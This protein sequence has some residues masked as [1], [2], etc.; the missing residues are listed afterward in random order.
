MENQANASFQ[1]SHMR[2]IVHDLFQ[3]NP[4]F[5]WADFLLTV[6]VA[7]GCAGIYFLSPLF[8]AQQILCLFVAG[9]ALHRLANFIHEI[10]HLHS[11]RSLRSF[12]VAWDI[13]V[14]IPTLMPSYFFHNHMAHHNANHFGTSSDC[15]YIPLGRG[16]LRNIGFFMCEIFLQPLFVVFRHAVVGPIS[17]LHPRLRQWVLENFSS[18]VFVWPCPRKI[19]T[20]APRAA[21]AAMDIACWLRASAIFG[22]VVLEVNP[23]Y[24]IPQLYF[25]AI[26]ALSLHYLRSLTAHRYLSD[27][28]KMSFGDQLMDSIDIT[29]GRVLTELL[30]P[31][32][33]RYHALHH[34]FPSLPYHNLGIANRRLLAQLPAD[35]PYR[36]LVYPSFWSVIRELIRHALESRQT[37]QPAAELPVPRLSDYRPPTPKTAWLPAGPA[38]PAELPAATG[39]D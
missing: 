26:F 21:W 13:L 18:F 22:L 25:L 7:Y 5:Y 16:P 38:S 28:K 4:L 20:N 15:E 9:F 17:F 32:G 27:G 24:R 10:A 19:P 1:L 39:F 8:S 29:G 35:S 36:Q 31:V 37:G 2:Q 3:P 12:R 6:T 14:G 23:W 30:Y 34:L 11:K 33:L